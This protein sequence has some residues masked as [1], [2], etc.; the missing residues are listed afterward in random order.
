MALASFAA[1][2]QQ[3]QSTA[4]SS[5]SLQPTTDH[6]HGGVMA[7][8]SPIRSIAARLMISPIGQAWTVPAFNLNGASLQAATTPM[9]PLA[10]A[11]VN[12]SPANFDFENATPRT[13][14]AMRSV[15]SPIR[16]RKG[17]SSDDWNMSADHTNSIWT[18]GTRRNCRPC[19]ARPISLKSN[20]NDLLRRGRERPKLC[21]I[22]VEPRS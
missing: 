20:S 3:Q 1:L 16:G 12:S 19:S 7:T 22:T 13:A 11:T 15:S 14:A 8:P 21:L 2:E 18:S 10:F 9:G 4:G 5:A 6:Q 17:R